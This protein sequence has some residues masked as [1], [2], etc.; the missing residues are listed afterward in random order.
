MLT[1]I[2]RHS[3]QVCNFFDI[4]TSQGPS[5]F[6]AP[7]RQHLIEVMD[8][9]L[10]CPEQKTLAALQRRSPTKPND[11]IRRISMGDVCLFYPNDI[12]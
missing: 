7:Q 4:I 1:R 9:L 10:V 12:P 3:P 6:S 11:L 5:L 8:A 2:L